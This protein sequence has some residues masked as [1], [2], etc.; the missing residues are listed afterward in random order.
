[1]AAK[2]RRITD[3]KTKSRSAGNPSLG[4]RLDV[5][6][7]DWGRLALPG[8]VVV[9]LAGLKLSGVIDATGL[10]LA[11]GVVFLLAS[12]GVYLTIVWR[13]LFPSWARIASLIMCCALIAGIGLPFFETIYPGEIGFSASLRSDDKPVAIDSDLSGFHRVEVYASSLAL[14]SGDR[15]ADG[16]YRLSL[17]DEVM[18]GRFSDMKRRMPSG[19]RGSRQ[20]QQTHLTDV[21]V[22]NLPSGEKRLEVNR[23]DT[24]IGPEIKVTLFPMIVPPPIVHLLLALS[25]A[26]AIGLDAWYQEKTVRWRLAPFVG[27]I[28]AFAVIFGTSYERGSVINTVVWSVIFGSAIGFTTGWALSLASRKILSR[29]R[30]TF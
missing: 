10:G 15:G 24:T 20:V 1:M 27:M 3:P 11:I 18:S 5:F 21:Y 7:D 8:L 17:A 22:L 13:N 28:A 6:K 19:R 2:I 14:R 26:F 4:E 29:I 30:T 25:L 16:D 9:V 23:L 12:L